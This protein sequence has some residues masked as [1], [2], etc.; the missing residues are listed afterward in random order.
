LLTI[1]DRRELFWEKVQD[2]RPGY[3]LGEV[4]QRYYQDNLFIPS[5]ILLPFA[6]EDE[7]NAGVWRISGCIL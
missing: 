1:V 7:E 4:L 6:V 2:Y 3:F 5:E